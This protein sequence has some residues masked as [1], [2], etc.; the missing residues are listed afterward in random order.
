MNLRKKIGFMCGLIIMA[1]QT[2]CLRHSEEKVIPLE[3]FFKR[4]EKSNFQVSPNGTFISF[5]QD[6]KGKQNIYVMGADDQEA[7]RITDILD[8][9]VQ[10][11]FWANG[12]E[13][14]FYKQRLAMDSLEVF[15][16]NRITKQVRTLIESSDVR[17]RW[18][19]TSKP[20]EG[21]LYL[22]INKRDKSVFDA[23]R[24][25]LRSSKLELI[26][27]NPGN[28]S[29]WFL[30]NKGNVRLAIESDGVNETLLYRKS[31]DS[32]FKKLFTNSFH[33]T[34]KPL[35]FVGSEP[36]H[37]YAFS[38]LSRDK[39]SLVE[40]DLTNGKEINEIFGH[41]DVDISEAG[42]SKK[43]GELL[44]A[45]YDLEKPK[46]KTFSS[47]MSSI[48]EDI[49]R[50]LENSPIKIVDQDTADMKFVVR[51]FSDSDPGSYYF[52]DAGNKALRKLADV[53]TS[54]S[55][56]KLSKMEPF[57]YKTRDGLQIDAY[58]TLPRGKG[59][60]NLPVVVIP[61]NGPAG[62]N[63]WGYNSE[64]QFLASRGY[65][66]FQMN[67]RGSTGFGKKFWSAGFLEWGGKIQNDIEDGVRTLI[68]QKIADPKRIAIYG[69][70]FGG[71]SA[72]YGACFHGDLYAAAVSYSGITNLFTYLKEIP[73][74]FKHFLQMYYEII[75][76]PVEDAS[77]F[78]EASPIF[79]ASQINIPVFIAQG[80]KD[81]RSNVN[82][83]NQFVRELKARNA[84]IT[85][86]LREEEGH[87]FNK[88]QNRIAFYSKLEDFLY[89]TV[90]T[91]K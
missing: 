49:E 61:H 84:P 41:P 69:F 64:V 58:L 89:K 65:A 25:D 32:Q 36:D 29:K 33:T 88:E 87:F 15:V 72:L 77:Y 80:G 19:P 26:A 78:K 50:K 12:E 91:R 2:A 37:I 66:V 20:I 14:V 16:V 57:R 67:Y 54:L 1:L 76:D 60:Q 18:L 63:V 62:R 34:I 56:Q 83:T 35:S 31:N 8:K 9:D 43:N 70:S 11:C 40:I 71:Y 73:P 47:R 3:E 82:E 10:N 86:M 7:I 27:K 55:K 75:G 4:P 85:Y 5:L 13:L 53:N 6:Y 30:D 44:Y 23:Y 28:V 38:N 52:Y 42:F 68:E 48:L 21:Y 17:L 46:R 22:A 90:Y 81:E 79:H 39:T 74:Y 45:S 59:R 24:L 51:S